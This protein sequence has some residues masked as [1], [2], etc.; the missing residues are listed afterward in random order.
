MERLRVVSFHVQSSE[1]GSPHLCQLRTNRLTPVSKIDFG[2]KHMGLCGPTNL[3]ALL[4]AEL[5]DALPC[6]MIVHW[7]S[8]WATHG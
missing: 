3:V 1:G 2:L 8:V 7:D 5:D 4:V 6:L